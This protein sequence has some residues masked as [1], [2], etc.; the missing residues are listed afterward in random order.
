MSHGREDRMPPPP[1]F[2]LKPTNRHPELLTAP[3]PT[4]GASPAQQV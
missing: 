4:T 2:P 3:A 1:P